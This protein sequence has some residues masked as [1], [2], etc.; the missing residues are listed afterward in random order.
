MTEGRVVGEEVECRQ[1]LDHNGLC[2]SGKELGVFAKA[3]E[4]F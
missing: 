3:T 2:R 4:R 1:R